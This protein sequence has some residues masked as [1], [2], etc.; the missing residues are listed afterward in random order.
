[1]RSSL[2]ILVAILAIPTV[3]AATLKEDFEGFIIIGVFPEYKPSQD[4]YTYSETADLGNVTS[5][6]PI[7]FGNQAFRF[8]RGAVDDPSSSSGQFNLVA[9]GQVSQINI[10]LRGTTPSENGA[11]SMQVVSFESSAPRRALVQFYVFCMDAVN[12]AACELRVRFQNID[13][14]GQV[15]INTTLGKKQFNISL[16][17]SWTASSYQLSVDGVDDGTFPFLELP[18]DFQRVG[19]AQYRGDIPAKLTLDNWHVLGAPVVNGTVVEG[20]M[21]TG[22]KNYLYNTHF[23]TSGSLFFFG[24][25]LFIV[26][27]AAV[28]VPTFALGKSNALA[29][30]AAF[31][32]VLVVMWLVTME[33]WPENIGI[34]AIILASALIGLFLRKFVLGI[35]NANGG[36]G[37]V[38]GALGYFVIASTFLGFSGYA[39]QTINVPTA[40]LDGDGGTDQ[41]FFG[42]VAE[43]IVTGGVFTFGLVGDCSQDTVS[44]TW[45]TITNILGWAQA[46]VDFLFQLLTFQLPIPVI[47][48]MMIVIPPASALAFVGIQLVRGVS[49]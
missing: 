31:Y 17:P 42:A 38:V 13:S 21:A 16:I 1:M 41:S 3:S 6:A 48:N 27:N 46:A 24:I 45:K 14:V 18:L 2:L 29:T 36:A 35:R 4:W 7:P 32:V 11:G 15:L 33:I 12:P 20:D 47:F 19:L 49:S 37:L 26:L 22:L 10:T 30:A 23:R 8:A 40:Q 44:S 25:I 28:L 9:P 43:C 39:A 5:V 34:T